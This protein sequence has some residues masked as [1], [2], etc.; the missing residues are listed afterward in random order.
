MTTTTDTPPRAYRNNV[1][2][3]P[4]GYG[5]F[6]EYSR[7]L[8]VFRVVRHRFAPQRTRFNG[9]FGA[10][11]VQKRKFSKSGPPEYVAQVR[12]R[13]IRLGEAS[14]LLH[15]GALA[16]LGD[17]KVLDL[18]TVRPSVPADDA[19]AEHVLAGHLLHF[20]AGPARTGD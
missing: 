20:G 9:R 15:A 10:G 8:G 12:V 2:V 1:V 6:A 17:P 4:D 19:H 14:A 3:A 16:L 13:S 5:A 7:I 11:D 18:P